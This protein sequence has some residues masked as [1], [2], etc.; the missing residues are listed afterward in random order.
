M[1]FHWQD[2]VMPCE[3]E[4]DAS[5]L[6]G[7]LVELRRGAVRAQP[8]LACNVSKRPYAT[9]GAQKETCDIPMTICECPPMFWHAAS[10]GTSVLA[11]AAGSGGAS[12]SYALPLR[13]KGQI[14]G[15]VS[16]D[17]YTFALFQEV[18]VQVPLC[19]HQCLAIF[20]R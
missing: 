2:R 1:K 7:G 13:S 11:A 9:L 4:S 18:D 17:M 12:R 19:P 5:S 3:Y 15:K 20:T 6:L 10:M 16:P 14:L 8:L